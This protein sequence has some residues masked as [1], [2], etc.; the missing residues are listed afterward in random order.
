MVN[1]SLPRRRGRLE[2]IPEI[3]YPTRVMLAAS[4]CR[5]PHESAKRT[6]PNLFAPR[7]P[8]TT[9]RT[10]RRV[11]A[12]LR[13]A[14]TKRMYGPPRLCKMISAGLNV[15]ANVSGLCG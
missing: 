6:H 9:K 7:N 4:Q 11:V 8:K 10:R 3:G 13:R 14:T 1:R 12:R 5:S 15:G 2:K